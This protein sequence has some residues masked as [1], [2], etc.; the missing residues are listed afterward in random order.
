[1]PHATIVAPTAATLLVS[2]FLLPCLQAISP[3]YLAEAKLEWSWDNNEP[4]HQ[5]LCGIC[6]G[7]LPLQESILPASTKEA[8]AWLN[9]FPSSLGLH[10]NDDI[11]RIAVGLSLGAPYYQPHTCCCGGKVDHLGIHVR[12]CQRSRLPKEATLLPC[13]NK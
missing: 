12:N 5:A 6:V 1:M 7:W 2:C 8:G 11:V 10:I 9:A 4:L 3:P 13:C